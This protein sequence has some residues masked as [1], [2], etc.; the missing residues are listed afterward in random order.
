MRCAASSSASSGVGT[1]AVAELADGA[2]PDGVVTTL[3]VASGMAETPAVP[4]V[5]CEGFEQALSANNTAHQV[6]TRFN[7]GPRWRWE[8]ELPRTSAE[9]RAHQA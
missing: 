3:V 7:V 5:S 9:P 1:G 4:A 8:P 2:A 6:R